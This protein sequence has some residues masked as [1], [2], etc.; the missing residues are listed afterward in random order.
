[1]RWEWDLG[2]PMRVLGYGGV[3]FLGVEGAV[4]GERGF[5]SYISIIHNRLKYYN[6]RGV[7]ELLMIFG[8]LWSQLDIVFIC[9]MS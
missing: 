6:G 3:T 5:L 1:V 9:I 7:G 8:S 2:V 4:R